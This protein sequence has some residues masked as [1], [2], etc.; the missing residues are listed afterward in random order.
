M[1]I[2]LLISRAFAERYGAE[3]RAAEA[4]HGV[5]F[6]HVHPPTEPDAR[7]APEV[8]A[9]IEIGFM[10][11]DLYPV[12]IRE[13]FIAALQAPNLRWMQGFSSGTDNAAFDAL[14]RRGVQFTNAAGS[15]AVPIAQTA[16]TGLLMLARGFLGWGQAQREHAWG[17][18]PHTAQPED[19]AG[20][21]LT[22]FGLG[23]IGTELARLGRALGLHVTGVRRTAP[24]AGAPIDEWLSP[25]R[26]A[27]VLPRT[28]WLALT[29]P[30][31]DATRGAIDARALALLPRGAQ[32]LNVARGAVAVES[33]VIA[34]LRSG[35]LGGA[36]L[37]VFEVEPLPAESPL[38]DLPNVIVTPHNSAASRGNDARVAQIFL[39][40]LERWLRKD[41]LE[42]LVT[43]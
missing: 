17:R 11:G 38:W 26:L 34:A 20:Q 4:R 12:G 29:C 15:T 39:A 42:N 5:R 30:L 1:A 21:R 22:V 7:L 25:D 8:S 33:D 32:L 40:N 14:L 28:D 24:P 6:E 19:L 37:D 41:P 16:I 10:S 13:Y 43:R 27:E 36:Y 2:G 23:A 31:T 18:I 9:R 3:L 35:Q